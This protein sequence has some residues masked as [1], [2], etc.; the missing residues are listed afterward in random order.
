MEDANF[1]I[2]EV[3]TNTQKTANNSQLFAEID[4]LNKRRLDI[5]AQLTAIEKYRKEYDA[6]KRGLNKSADSLKPIEFLSKNLSDQLLESYETKIFIDSLED[7]L[8]TIQNNLSKKVVEPLRVTGD[9]KAL[10]EE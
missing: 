1:I 10:Q 8:K 4:S 7:S 6:Y 5:K 2:N 9:A 3:I